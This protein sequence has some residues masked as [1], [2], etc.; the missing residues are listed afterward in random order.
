MIPQG[1]L[2]REQ[3]GKAISE[4]ENQIVRIDDL[5]YTVRSQSAK[6]THYEVIST[7]LG[8][9][10]SC[11]DHVYRNAKC[12]H[13][14]AV[15]FSLALRNAVKRIDSVTS[16]S[17]CQYCKS[18]NI[19]RD[20]LR[21]NKYGDLQ[22]YLCKNC[23][24]HFTLNYGFEKMHASPQAITS[25][26]QLYFSGES[27]RNVQ[28]FLL[29]QGVK[30]SHVSVM[31][32]ISKYV[33]LMDEYVEKITPQV[34]K[35]WRT[36]E[37]HLKIKGKKSWLFAI[38]DDETRFWIA[39]QIADKKGVSDIRPVFRS[40]KNIAEIEPKTIISDGAPNFAVATQDEFPNAMHIS[41][42]RLEGRFTITRWKR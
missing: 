19:V 29:L 17:V 4:S 42:I 25:A 38:M 21:H 28:K 40:A 7:E 1:N 14:F 31:N 18:P 35:T 39:Q 33:S 16:S 9:V 34:S 26:M 22:V 11:P 5:T 10:C 27:L 3:R 36:D 20:G 30:I 32:W 8:W 41:E 13:I 2:T 15:E 37:L 12:K 24:R 23:N 6:D